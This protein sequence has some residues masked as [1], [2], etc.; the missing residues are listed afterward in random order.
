VPTHGT[1][2]ARPFHA[3]PFG[4]MLRPRGGVLRTE[5]LSLT[6]A[7]TL[8]K[9]Y[10]L[11]TNPAYRDSQAPLQVVGRIGT[12]LVQEVSAAVDELH[13]RIR[14]DLTNESAAPLN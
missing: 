1:I 10:R 2:G 12:N 4:N 7:E 8:W 13:R 6:I 9:V 11:W 3:Y 14:A 5:S